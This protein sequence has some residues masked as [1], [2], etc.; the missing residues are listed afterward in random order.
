VVGVEREPALAF[1]ILLQA[2]W[3]V[4]STIVG[5]AFLI[6]RGARVVRKRRVGVVGPDQLTRR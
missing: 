2:T 4:P 1:S 6:R 5:G 3:Y